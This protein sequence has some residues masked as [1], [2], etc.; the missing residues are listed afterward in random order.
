M[1]EF[2][3]IIQKFVKDPEALVIDPKYPLLTSVFYIMVIDTP[4]LYHSVSSSSKFW[5]RYLSWAWHLFTQQQ[6]D[7]PS[8]IDYVNLPFGMMTN[9]S[10]LF[11][12]SSFIKT[13]RYII[14]LCNNDD[15]LLQHP[16]SIKFF[17][18]LMQT[19]QENPSPLQKRKDIAYKNNQHSKYKDYIYVESHLIHSQLLPKD[20]IKILS[21]FRLSCILNRRCRCCYKP[22][23]E[24]RY[25]KIQINNEQEARQNMIA[26]GWKCKARG[27][28]GAWAKYKAVNYKKKSKSNHADWKKCKDCGSYYCSKKCQKIDWVKYYHRFVCERLEPFFQTS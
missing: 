26:N 16:G 8:L 6:I 3:E 12:K 25:I 4:S 10:K 18:L 20:G 21:D 13:A 24:D 14:Q 23:F 9:P 2:K 15:K 19:Y 5:T 28:K 11:N 17:V 7:Y 1:I 22:Y 27:A